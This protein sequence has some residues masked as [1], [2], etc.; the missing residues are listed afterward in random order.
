MLDEDI[1]GGWEGSG[2]RIDDVADEMESTA[3]TRSRS[4]VRT[5]ARGAPGRCRHVCS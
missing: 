5:A 4:L 2:D 1:C 3:L